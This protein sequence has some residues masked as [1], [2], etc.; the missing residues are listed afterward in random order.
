MEETYPEK[1]ADQ[2][3]PIAKDTYTAINTGIFNILFVTETPLFQEPECI[4]Y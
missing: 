3:Q 4:I 2:T 1:H